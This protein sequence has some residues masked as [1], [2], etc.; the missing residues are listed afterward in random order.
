MLPEI[1]WLEAPDVIAYKGS[2]EWL[3]V[4]QGTDGY[5]AFLGVGDPFEFD[6]SAIPFSVGR[7]AMGLALDTETKASRT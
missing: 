4:K 1:G 3:G 2:A 6:K 7:A 5:N